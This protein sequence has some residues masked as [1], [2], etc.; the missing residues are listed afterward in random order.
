M[1]MPS[2]IQAMASP[3]IPCAAARI[4]RPAAITR[5]E[6]ASTS[7]PPWRSISRPTEG[8]TTADSSNAAENRPK[9]KSLETCSAA[10]IGAPRIAGR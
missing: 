9:N 10:A 6:A 7:R 8:P 5:F 4:T 2:T 3:A 1:P